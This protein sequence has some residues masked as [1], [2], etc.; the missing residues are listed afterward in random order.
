MIVAAGRLAGRATGMKNGGSFGCGQARKLHQF[1]S[2]GGH[3][4]N[5]CPLAKVRRVHA[6]TIAEFPVRLI[7]SIL[8]GEKFQRQGRELVRFKSG[9]NHAAQLRGEFR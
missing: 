4:G 8:P 2:S 1:E 9:I 7:L 3:G 5:A 6:L